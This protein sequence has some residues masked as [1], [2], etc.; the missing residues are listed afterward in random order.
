MTTFDADTYN[1]DR[2]MVADLLEHL[3]LI[4]ANAMEAA[5]WIVDND[6]PHRGRIMSHVEGLLDEL[7][8][9]DLP[10]RARYAHNHRIERRKTP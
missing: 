9:V 7:E 6:E 3:A 10:G 5:G 4:D 8:A 1:A 2:G